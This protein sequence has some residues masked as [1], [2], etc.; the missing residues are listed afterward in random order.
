MTRIALLAAL[1]LLPRLAIAEFRAG[2]GTWSYDL[3][4][5]VTDNNDTYDFEKDLELQTAGRG[6]ALLAWDTGAGAPDWSASFTRFGATGHHVE[7]VTI[8][9][10]PSTQTVTIDADGDFRDYDVTLSWPVHAGDLA[11]GLGLTLKRL[12]GEVLIDDSSN[13][14][15]RHEHYRETFPQLH[16]GLRLPLGSAFALTGTA[17]GASYGGNRATEW[18]VGAELKLFTH[19]LLEAGYQA[20]RYKVD[21]DQYKLDARLGGALLRAG[22]F[23]D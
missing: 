19:L 9:I 11:L 6:S 21:V 20:K 10:P 18:R 22:F 17:Q 3:K 4:G 2:F 5:Q 14:P 13:P 16:L 23:W 7:T 15:P 1:C 8:M 12:T